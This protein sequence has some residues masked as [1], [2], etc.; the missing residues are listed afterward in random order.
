MDGTI[1]DTDGRPVAG[2]RVSA[3][4]LNGY[5][6]IAFS[7]S[8]P[9]GRFSLTRPM[10]RV[11]VAVVANGYISKALTPST[12]SQLTIALARPSTETRQISGTVVDTRGKPLAGARVRLMDW[13]WPVG[14]AFYVTADD[15]GSFRFAVDAAGS[16]DLMVDDPRYISD[17]AQLP[18]DSHERAR[19]V[20]YERA[21]II[22]QANR[23]DEAVLRDLCAPLTTAGIRQLARSLQAVQVLGLGESTHGTREYVEL[24]SHIV[25]AL[26]Q[27]GWLTTIAL[28]ASW[29]EVAR[30][31]DYVRRSRGSGREA[32]EALAY[33][34]WRTEEFLALV[35]MIRK[36]NDGLPANKKIEFLGIDY[37]PPGA[38]VKFLHEALEQPGVAPSSALSGL[39]PLR[40][41]VSWP[42]LSKLSQAERDGALQSL[43]ELTRLAEASS[44]VSLSARQGLRITQQIIESSGRH[45]DFRDRVM[46]GAALALV[47]AS[48][49]ERRLAIWAHG[50]H[51]AEGPSE[52]TLPM[53]AYLKA[54]LAEQYRA[55][56][57][58]FYDGSFRTYSGLQGKMVNHAVAPPPAFYFESVVHQVSPSQS[59]ILD[60]RAAARR[61]GV[62]DWI[63]V[64]KHVR[65][66]GGMEISESYP[67]PPIVVPDLWSAMIF[68]PST[69]PTT[70]LDE[71]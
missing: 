7:V 49:K 61:T 27:G 17:F 36:R 34:P 3:I 31:D 18:H 38:T 52:G 71:R 2:A 25:E 58:M 12:S 63:A 4:D 68:V 65:S 62:G 55:V 22:A 32:V 59:C 37:A 41:I 14:V 19:L 35:E 44:R 42:E 70:S 39:A 21:W 56:G 30:I 10:E 33:W 9:R 53:G 64:P 16:Y 20:A 24:R 57:A 67:W 54:R 69:T 47:F 28:E 8:D 43:Q 15:A 1:T 60:V 45:E 46:A 40:R 26:I 13:A 5:R 66:Y 23:V 11:A 29:E 6:G 51:L 48:D 50:Q